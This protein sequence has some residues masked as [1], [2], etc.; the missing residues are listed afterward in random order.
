MKILI[1]SS[2]FSLL[3]VFLLTTILQ[4]QP[5]MGWRHAQMK[6][7]L[8]LT[9]IQ[10][11]Q[12]EKLR[13]DHQK[14]MID[15]RAKLQKAKVEAREVMSKDDFKR[16]D[17]LAAQEKISKIQN[18]IHSTA[19]NHRMDIVD[20]LNKDQRKIFLDSNRKFDG[21]KRNFMNRSRTD[22][23]SRNFGCSPRQRCLW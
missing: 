4:A 21:K 9:E 5:G 23:E 6:E 7:K 19:A 22:G 12:L 1:K 3:I 2:F 15:L 11:T 8:N 17:Y 18:E 16:S 10:E 14:S 13:N 20:I